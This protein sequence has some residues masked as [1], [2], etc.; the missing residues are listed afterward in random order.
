MLHTSPQFRP[1]P[2]YPTYPP[3]HVGDYLED[4]FYNQFTQDMP[5]VTRDYIAVSWTTLYCDNKTEG[6]QDFLN[7]L[8]PTKKYFTILQHDDAPKHTLPPNTICFSA[9][10]NVI[11]D[12]TVPIPLICSKLPPIESSEK[13]YLATFVGSNT[14]PIRQIMCAA[15]Q[16]KNNCPIYL[17][18]WSPHVNKNEFDLFIEYATQSKYLLCPRGYGLN[19]FR[20]YEAFQLNCVPV[21]ITDKMYLPWQDELDWTTFSVPINNND[22]SSLYEKLNSISEDKYMKLLNHG[23]EI[24][25]SHFSLNGM[26]NNIIKRLK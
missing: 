2:Q 21:I 16:E 3:Y 6:L 24:Y 10:G 7:S 13:K 1:K 23:K 22:I 8:D 5:N 18:N 19:S 12:K 20:L 25:E 26:Y 4:Y 15:L 9:G 11:S 14:H 17:K